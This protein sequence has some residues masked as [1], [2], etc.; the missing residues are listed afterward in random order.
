MYMQ[1]SCLYELKEYTASIDFYQRALYYRPD[2]TAYYRGLALAQARSGEL[3]NAE[4]TLEIVSEKDTDSLDCAIIRAELDLVQGKYQSA[5]DQYADMTDR[6]D[7][8]QILSRIY[9]SG[10]EALKQ[11]G[12]LDEY[13]EWLSQAVDSLKENGVLQ[14]EMLAGAYTEKAF[15]DPAYSRE[16]NE[17]AKKH[18]QS[19]V[20]SGRG[21]ILTSL[22]LAVVMENLEEYQNSKD[23]LLSL[24]KRYPEDYRVYMRLAFLYA[25]WQSQLSEDGRDYAKTLEYYNLAVRYYEQAVAN[26]ENDDEM[27][28]LQAL[29]EQLRISGWL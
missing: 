14:E 13:I 28:R 19:V 27:L 26:G 3:D 10:A 22:N 1:A 9:L 23:C 17:L 6:T 15:V 2:Q 20:D 16:W 5:F 8:P 11:L 7:D 4:R 29:I 21:N 24:Q 25:D 12:S 18:L